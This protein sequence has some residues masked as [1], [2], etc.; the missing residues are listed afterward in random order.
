MKGIDK[1]CL[2]WNTVKNL[3]FVQIRYQIA[4][5]IFRMRKGKLID[6]IQCLA[7]PESRQDIKILIPELDCENTYLQ[8]FCIEKLMDNVIEILHE[9][10]K[11]EN[12]WNVITASHLWNYNLH[13][14]EFL[15]P[16][17]VK[18]SDTTEDQYFAK[19]EE[20]VKSWMQQSCDDSFEPY[21]ISMRIPNIL[22]CMEL[23]K[24]KL[25]GTELK[26]K[27][28]SS[29]Y[30]QYRFLLRSQE[31]ALLANH[32]FENL[33]AIVI[34][35]LLFNELD[36]YHKYF[37]LFLKQIDEQIL[38]DGLHYELSLMY[39][40][41]ILEDIMRV[42]VVLSSANHKCD[43]EK[44]IPAM[45]MMVSAMMNLEQGFERT[46]LF[47]DAGC[48]VSKSRDALLEAGERICAYA[49]V[50]RAAFP[51]SGYYK[52]Y[53]GNCTVLFDCGEIGPSYMG[54]HSHC[55]CLSFE[56]SVDGR[57]ILSN[58]GT[59]QYQGEL[60]SFFRS[61]SAHNTMM[62]DNREQSE[63]WG[64]HRAGRRINKVEGIQK[65]SMLIGRFQSYH[66]DSFQRKLEWKKDAMIIIDDLKTYDTDL[67]IARQFFH[68]AP[69]Y[70]YERKGKRISIKLGEST[71]AVV[72]LPKECDY[73]IHT[74]GMITSYAEDFGEYLHKEVLE[75]RTQFQDEV[76]SKIEIEV[77][78]GEQ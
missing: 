8:R 30:Q 53:A 33:K 41:I 76:Q 68:L 31:L 1:T 22:I 29:I 73:L 59:G 44:L 42:Y 3:K 74:E 50:E 40:K 35:S 6:S 70:T 51:K 61:T 23:L 27:L 47:N 54:G 66:G 13:Y 12:N 21:T 69:G 7:L 52:L 17:A 77:K 5:R 57:V 18:Y 49:Y 58:S 36:I 14:L 60:R 9:S 24:D 48:N 16:L 39:H 46:P 20:L 10:H 38:P 45:R 15:I 65:S 72:S 56:L 26:E 11:I 25:A 4:R 71:M 67:H 19:W 78:T 32:Y 63:L 37:D 55:D 43:A 62:I 34:G 64:E 75:V 28:N 2:Y